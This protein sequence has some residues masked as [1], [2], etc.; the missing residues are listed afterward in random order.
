M[1]VT[2]GASGRE[3]LIDG[4]AHLLAQVRVAVRE[5]KKAFLPIAKTEKQVELVQEAGKTVPSVGGDVDEWDI[6][7][8]LLPVYRDALVMEGFKLEGLR[9]REVEMK[10]SPTGTKKKMDE[11][12]KHLKT[13]GDQRDLFQ[14]IEEENRKAER[15]AKAGPPPDPT[16]QDLLAPPPKAKDV[17]P[18]TPFAR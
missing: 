7:G 4:L 15:A 2:L 12:Q 11:I 3:F 13:L 16:Q 17:E 14:L 9:K 6:P 5:E 18:L 1:N 8:E 10:V